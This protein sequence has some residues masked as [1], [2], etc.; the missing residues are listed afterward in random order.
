M[1]AVVIDMIIVLLPYL[2]LLSNKYS[3]S[4]RLI[5]ISLFQLTI[6]GILTVISLIGDDLALVSQFYLIQLLTFP[7]VVVNCI[8]IGIYWIIKKLN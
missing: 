8:I 3:V 7:I 5:F 2:Y 1:K 4:I 6:M